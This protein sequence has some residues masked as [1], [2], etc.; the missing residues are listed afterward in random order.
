MFFQP[1]SPLVCLRFRF[2]EGNSVVKL[3]NITNLSNIQISERQNNTCFLSRSLFLVVGQ[4]VGVCEQ[5]NLLLFWSLKL[6][7]NVLWCIFGNFEPQADYGDYGGGAKK[8]QPYAE[9][10][11]IF[12]I[13]NNINKIKGLYTMCIILCKNP[14]FFVFF[15]SNQVIYYHAYPLHASFHFFIPGNFFI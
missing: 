7:F 9:R 2:W 5:Q 8:K 11:G 10:Y 13:Y 1:P 14:P 4:G 12:H 6:F 15:H 3:P